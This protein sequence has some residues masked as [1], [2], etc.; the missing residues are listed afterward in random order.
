[1]C[2][3][4]SSTS[5]RCDDNAHLSRDEHTYVYICQ[6]KK[7]KTTIFFIISVFSFRR[8]S[9]YWLIDTVTFSPALTVRRPREGGRV[10]DVFTPRH[11][12]M[13]A[14]GFLQRQGDGWVGLAVAAR[15]ARLNDQS[16]GRRNV[17]VVPDFFRLAT[18]GSGFSPCDPWGVALWNVRMLPAGAWKTSTVYLYMYHFFFNLNVYRML[19]QAE[20]HLMPSGCSFW[21]QK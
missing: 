4:S 3:F 15:L 8:P 19:S 11:V 9:L 10:A 16:R 1:M 21:S 17:P 20:P 7:I 18:E 6:Q 14:C 13:S 2:V 12:R 5:R